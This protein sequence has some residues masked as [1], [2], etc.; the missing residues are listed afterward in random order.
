MSEKEVSVKVDETD[1]L[2][3]PKKEAIQKRME[4]A[5]IELQSQLKSYL[6][7]TP[8]I[9][10]KQNEFEIRFG[11]K[12]MKPFS[13]TDYDN[14][15]RQ[16][17][18]AGFYSTNET[19]EQLL[20]I[21][22]EFKNPKTGQDT[23]S[24]IRAEI[25]GGF[26]IEKFCET[27]DI[28]K[29]IEK[30]H[31]SV[32]FTQ[33]MGQKGRDE[34]YLK[35][36]DFTDMNFRVSWQVESDYSLR[37]PAVQN[38]ISTWGD[39]KKVFRHL[40]RVRFQHDTYP[41]FA[42]ISI[43]RSS[44]V[45]RGLHG[46][47]VPIPEYTIQ[48]AN[49]F[50]NP[51]VYEIEF[52]IDNTRVGRGTI[53]NNDIELLL[54]DIRKCIR[55]VMSGL[56]RSNYPISL[57]ERESVLE[58]YE[59]IIYS[60]KAQE[61]DEEKSEEKAEEG[62]KA[63]PEKNKWKNRLFIGPSSV[64]LQ[65]ENIL[66]VEYEDNMVTPNIRYNYTVTDKAD[67]ERMLALINSEGLIYFIDK[68]MNV[69][70]TGSKT[71]E[72]K[73]FNSILD[74]EFIKYGKTNR[75][76]N[77][78]AAF[79]IY[80]INKKSVRE[81][82]FVPLNTQEEESGELFRLPLLSEF[83]GMLKPVSI[84]KENNGAGFWKQTT[85]SGEK[86]WFN[87]KTGKISNEEPDAVRNASCILRVECKKFYIRR[88][89]TSIFNCCDQI[90][91]AESDGI[92]PYTID[93]LIF[94]PANTGVGSNKAGE[95][96]EYKK[97][98]WNLS[99]KWKPSNYNTV[100]F[101]VS[102]IKD[103]SGKDKVSHLYED[104]FST[105][106]GIAQYKTL[107]LRC[108]FDKERHLLTNPFHSLI[109]GLFNKKEVSK[110]EE[111]DRYVPMRFV[112]SNPYQSDA[113]ITNIRLKPNGDNMIMMTEEGEYF[114]E[115]TIVEFRYDISR[116]NG[117]RWIPIRVRHDKTQKMQSGKSEYGNAYHVANDIWKSYYNP[118]TEDMIKTGDNIPDSVDNLDI[119]YNKSSDE[120]RTKSMR[121]FHNLFV[122]KRLI[123]GV[124]NRDD[125]LIDYAVGKA[126]DLH[127]WT[128]SR[129]GFVL[130]V[131]IANDNIT[132]VVDGACARYLN[133]YKIS[134]NLP[135]AL[136]LNGNSSKNIRDGSAFSTEQ[137]KKI[138]KAV[139]GQG[140]KDASLLGR[141]VYNQ[142]DVAADGFHVS[143]CQFAVHY[144]FESL[145][146]LHGFLRNLA[147][148]TRL[149]GYFVGT[150]YDGLTIFNA[151]KDIT[152]NEMISFVTDNKTK[153]KICE[154]TKKYSD[155]GFPDDELSV[156]YAIDVFQ[157]TINKSFRE[158]LVN[159]I[160]FQR[161][162]ENYGFV[163]V[164]REEAKQMG[165]PDATGM[166]SELYEQMQTEVKQDHR[167]KANYKDALYMSDGEKSLS[168]M[169]RYF[170]FKKTT[171]VNAAQIEQEALKRIKMVNLGDEEV[172]DFGEL[173]DA[174]DEERKKKAVTGKIRKL[175][176]KIRLTKGKIPLEIREDTNEED[177]VLELPMGIEKESDEVES[178]SQ[179]EENIQL[180][181][182]EDDE[183]SKKEVLKEVDIQQ[184]EE[185]KE[186]KPEKITI[187]VKKPKKMDK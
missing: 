25:I 168:F 150:C 71:L 129:L 114:E 80:F 16:L 82:G 131:D 143:S 10:G 169:N 81:K 20:R 12:S 156:G 92:F 155:S 13:R 63:Q 84:I 69:V 135:G 88:P 18:T 9:D 152:E 175:N 19:G 140:P 158:Y 104:G 119:Y 70:F 167:K 45:R 113:G 2:K 126:G 96:C 183:E 106:D 4:E 24:N 87:Q 44:R 68:N 146:Q 55:I 99:F 171:T 27:N 28:N 57:S 8:R 17:K 39:S 97:G 159:F 184:N 11:T 6:E 23:I 46:M 76:L 91:N 36:I 15:V 38:I 54:T 90:L 186:N 149:N 107:E 170:V 116:E 128:Q 86:I 58:T 185:P 108:G 142:Y 103:K 136:F 117:W 100:D 110:E 154:I 59:K 89:G 101:L 134:E 74:G 145:V 125:I 31:S 133:E 72:R 29:L 49:V 127:K 177:D 40:N 7:N 141:G 5:K 61:E 173:G 139:F 93:G 41:L 37:S 60:R 120:S 187:R 151:L 111:H 62:K 124:S 52:E 95:A 22:P 33:K 73:C 75:L 56:Q 34:K 165:L 179:D 83:I 3:N 115:D 51:I 42:D 21:N 137:N 172:V 174:F 161:I 162:L 148:C 132:N 178:Q 48:K 35:K 98:T 118:V 144:F 166:F 64:P 164:T 122:K 109:M 181:L 65:V 67:G 77:L 160:F 112:P 26:M 66:E 50:K 30:S 157:E 147:E 78:Y 123:M 94:T 79:D 32:T 85:K 14:V 105:M 1:V 121:N 163:L 138:I 53:Y 43:V 130:G 180:V 176:V 182:D 47:P 153:K 102:T